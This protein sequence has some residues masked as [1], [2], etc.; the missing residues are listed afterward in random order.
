MAT[1]EGET[2]SPAVRW[3]LWT[4]CVTAWTLVLTT[5]A[6][7]HVMHDVLPAQ[8]TFPVAKT[9]HVLG[10]AFLTILSGWLH[11]RGDRRWFLLAFLSLHGMATEYIQTYVPDRS[12]SWRD[13]GLDHIG[14]VLGL[15]LSWK[16]WRS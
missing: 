13:V 9:A 4:L 8:A 10:Y 2:D 14:V 12:G 1:V 16:W 3:T 11:V 15:V 6:P 7:A 5:S